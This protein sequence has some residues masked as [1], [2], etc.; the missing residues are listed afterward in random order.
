MVKQFFFKILVAGPGGA[1]KTSL[2][3]Q[4]IK[5]MFDPSTKMTIG[6]DFFLKEV[7]MGTDDKVSL[8]I[9][10]LGGQKMFQEL[11][12]DY[13][14]GAKGALVLIDLTNFFQTKRVQKWVEL[15]RSERK[16]LPIIFIGNKSDL[17]D[18]IMVDDKYLK[19]LTE[20]HNMDAVLK[21]SA[22]TGEN[23]DK[24]FELLT[25]AILDNHRS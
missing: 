9:W 17:K 6:V 5:N 18:D 14:E 23:V 3:Q 2:L 13:V 22:K 10:D 16:D 11:H 1:G 7:D 12:K 20:E 19:E 24:A 4:Y 15:V 8:Q 25:K 21:T